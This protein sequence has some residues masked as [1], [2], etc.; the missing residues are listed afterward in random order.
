M[1]SQNELLL[2]QN[3]TILVSV[4]NILPICNGGCSQQALE[5]KDRR[6]CIRGYDEKMIKEFV[7]EKLL[8]VLD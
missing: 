8:Y 6:Y 4:C 3:Y 2:C 7:K 1:F 5:N